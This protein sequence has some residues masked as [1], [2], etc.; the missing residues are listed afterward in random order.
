MIEVC[1]AII[2]KGE[3]MLAVQRGPGSSHPNKWEFPGGKIKENET[4]ENCIVRE[5]KEELVADIKIVSQLSPVTYDYGIKQ[6]NLIPFVCLIENTQ[7]V[8]TEHTGLLWLKPDDWQSLDWAEADA[9]LI[10]QNYEK[11]IELLR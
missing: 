7:I 4:A 11:L 9:L 2:V 8:L 6:I 3:K 5:I 10:G 1:C